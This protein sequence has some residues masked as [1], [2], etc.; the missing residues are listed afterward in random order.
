MAG[1]IR[2]LLKLS[3][4]RKMLRKMIPS[5]SITGRGNRLNPQIAQISQIRTVPVRVG[6]HGFPRAAVKKSTISRKDAKPQRAAEENRILF[7]A[8]SVA[9]R[10]CVIPFFSFRGTLK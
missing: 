9:S 3:F 5:P 2:R 1:V 10:L 6:A 8:R 4:K 7:F